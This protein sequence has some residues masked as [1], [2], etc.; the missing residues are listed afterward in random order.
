MNTSPK[1]KP[2]EWVTSSKADLMRL[3]RGVIRNF[4]FALYV[5][6]IG[7]AHPN[8]KPLQGFG[9]AG[10]LEIVEDFQ[11]NAY[12]AVYT[13]RFQEAIFVLHVFQ[14]KSRKGIATPKPDLDLIKERLKAARQMAKEM[15]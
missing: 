13:V 2:L 12:R 7:G 8:A 5:A 3:P 11:G 6:Q 1:L 4:G 15:K 14:K 9:S 10:V